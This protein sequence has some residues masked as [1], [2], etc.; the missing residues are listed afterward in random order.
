LADRLL[1]KIAEPPGAGAAAD[2]GEEIGEDF[3]ALR[4]VGDF[5]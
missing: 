3:F 4:R 5:G 1:G 2:V